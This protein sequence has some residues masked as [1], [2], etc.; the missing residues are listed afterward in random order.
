[1]NQFFFLISFSSPL[2]SKGSHNGENEVKSRISALKEYLALYVAV[3]S[4]DEEM[5]HVAEL[6][7]ESWGERYK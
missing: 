7:A 2:P 1:M 6:S 4:V 3:S 5:D